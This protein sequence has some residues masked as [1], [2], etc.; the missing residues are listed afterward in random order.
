[1]VWPGTHVAWDSLGLHL[2]EPASVY[3]NSALDV[4]RAPIIS[5]IG[6]HVL[7]YEVF[8]ENF[9]VLRFG[10]ALVVR[11]QAMEAEARIVASPFS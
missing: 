11:E 1:M 9:A 2:E 4:A 6:K 10:I 3:L 7:G 8:A 5:A